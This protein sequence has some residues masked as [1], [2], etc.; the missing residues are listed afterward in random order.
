MSGEYK[1]PIK[2]CDVENKVALSAFRDKRLQWNNWLEDDPDHAIWGAVN[3]LVWR[4]TSFAAMSKLAFEN[5]EGPLNAPLLRDAITHGHFATQVLALRRLNDNGSDVISLRRLLKDVKKYWHLLTRENFVCF[6]GLPY[7]YQGVRDEAWATFWATRPEGVKAQWVDTTGPKAAG[8]SEYY[9]LH[10]DRLSGVSASNRSRSDVLPTALLTK[11]ES[12]LAASGLNDI[13][14]WSHA[15]LAHSGNEAK[16]QDVAHIQMA[17]EKLSA[18]IR[19]I[20]R[21]TEALAG[22]IL[23]IGS[24]RS[25]LMPVA[26]YDVFEKLDKPVASPRE[27]AQAQTVWTEKSNEWDHAIDNVRDDLM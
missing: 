12:W 19:E 1:Y 20:A 5:S 17:N 4:D 27:Q 15:Y 24:R 2:E 13:S 16:R 8:S 3:D 14:S 6:D 9:H 7:D 18:G 25:A 26:Q 10:F 11:I 23:F 21:I 22:E